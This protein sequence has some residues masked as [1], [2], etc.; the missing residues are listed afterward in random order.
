MTE[1]RTQQKYNTMVS[2]FPKMDIISETWPGCHRAGRQRRS[3]KEVTGP[4]CTSFCWVVRK[5]P[6][7]LSWGQRSKCLKARMRS[8]ISLRTRVSDWVILNRIVSIGMWK[9]GVKD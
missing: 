4:D 6:C 7:E 5:K 9:K 8:P 2:C 3:R 1:G